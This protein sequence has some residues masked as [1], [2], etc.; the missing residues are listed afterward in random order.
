MYCMMQGTPT[1]AH[2]QPYQD[3]QTTDGCC[4]GGVPLTLPHYWQPHSISM[5]L[6]HYTE[7]ACGTPIAVRGA[8]AKENHYLRQRLRPGDHIHAN[9][10]L[11]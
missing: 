2:K 10:S 6:P 8:R 3:I 5:I 9:L 1:T 4:E 11:Q 7:P